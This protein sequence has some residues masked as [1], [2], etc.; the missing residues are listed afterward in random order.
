M[1]EIVKDWLPTAAAL[2]AGTWI[3]LTW[4]LERRHQSITEMPAVF[5]EA[6]V[7]I[8]P[9]DDAKFLLTI[10]S[11]WNNSSPL[12]IYVDTEKTRIDVF[13]IPDDADL[14]PF[15]LKSI[16]SGPQ[17][18]SYPFHDMDSFTFEPTRVNQVR[19]QFFLAT[20]SLY[21]IRVKIYRDRKRHGGKT[22]A[23]TREYVVDARE[24]GVSVER[25]S[26]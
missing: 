15:D 8:N 2:V 21:G 23:W 13:S 18:R 19:G 5:G 4:R 20:G 25:L 1:L 16:N 10:Y 14:G 22:Y 26:L 11:N 9:I 7:Q 12:P 24:L 6:I 17:H 3:L